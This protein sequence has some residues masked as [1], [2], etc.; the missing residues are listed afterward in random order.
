MCSC[1]EACDGR[2]TVS[3]P[4]T[5]PL[6]PILPPPLPP[7]A[8]TWIDVEPSSSGTGSSDRGSATTFSTRADIVIRGDSAI[9]SML[10]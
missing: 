9:A 2:S 3:T 1:G 8:S 7:A 4:P 10:L 6:P 5:P